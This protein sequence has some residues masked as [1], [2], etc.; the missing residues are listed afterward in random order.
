MPLGG[1]RTCERPC[2]PSRNDI[3]ANRIL[4]AHIYHRIDPGIPW[5]TL[6]RDVPK[7]TLEL[8]Q[9]RFRGRAPADERDRGVE[10][11]TGLDIDS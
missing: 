5:E 11:D 7:L 1:S 8:E 3:R 6:A 2:R 10:H 9:W 4:V